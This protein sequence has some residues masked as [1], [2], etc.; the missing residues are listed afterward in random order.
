MQARPSEDAPET[1]EEAAN[2]EE[3]EKA[4]LEGRGNGIQTPNAHA[5]GRRIQVL[6]V[7]RSF[8]G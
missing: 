7:T 3:R 8:I 2:F 6:A 1:D 5:C 4:Q